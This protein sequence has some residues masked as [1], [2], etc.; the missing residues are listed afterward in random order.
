MAI[1][2]HPLRSQA[3]DGPAVAVSDRLYQ[4]ATQQKLNKS[5]GRSAAALNNKQQNRRAGTNTR[6]WSGSVPSVWCEDGG[7]AAATACRKAECPQ[8]VVRG[9]GIAGAAGGGEWALP[10][11]TF[12][13][14][15]AAG[16]LLRNAKK[17]ALRPLS[18]PGLRLILWVSLLDD[19]RELKS[20]CRDHRR[21]TGQQL[22]ERPGAMQASSSRS[23]STL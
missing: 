12:D 23:V 11:G 3:G 19:A 15:A 20:L 2:G 22:P 13:L 5:A 16:R 7:I 9:W 21:R 1:A 17:L 10:Y 14:A 4:M 6:P 18:P 8:R